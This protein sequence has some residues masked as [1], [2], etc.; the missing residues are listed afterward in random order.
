M[1]DITHPEEFD[2]A[3]EELKN[4]PFGEFVQMALDTFREGICDLVRADLRLELNELG[5][6]SDGTE[7]VRGWLKMNGLWTGED[8]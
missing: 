7:S 1:G 3:I 6:T 8:I 4:G 5:S 2:E